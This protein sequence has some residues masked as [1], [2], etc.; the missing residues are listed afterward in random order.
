MDEPTNPYN[1][2]PIEE[3]IVQNDLSRQHDG[4]LGLFTPGEFLHFDLSVPHLH[5]SKSYSLE[6]SKDRFALSTVPQSALEP[7]GARM[8]PPPLPYLTSRS[9]SNSYPAEWVNS[10]SF[11]G[12]QAPI[13]DALPPPPWGPSLSQWR[14]PLRCPDCLI[15]LRED[16]EL[17]HHW[18][19]V[20]APT[21]R[22]WI[23]VQPENPPFQPKK[24]LDVCKM[25][26]Q[27]KQYNV[28]Y[29][30]AAH[31]RRAHFAPS[32]RG[33]RP[34]GEVETSA[35]TLST[36]RS[37][38]PNVG[39]LKA[40]GWLK[41]ITVP[42]ER[43]S[44]VAG[45]QDDGVN[46]Y[47]ADNVTVSGVDQMGVDVTL[48]HDRPNQTTQHVTAPTWMEYTME[49]VVLPPGA[50]TDSDGDIDSDD[51][52]RDRTASLGQDNF[53]PYIP[54]P[55][56]HTKLK[57]RVSELRNVN[58]ETPGPGTPEPCNMNDILQLTSATDSG[59]GTGQSGSKMDG[60]SVA[61]D[62]T[63]S[64][65]TDGSQAPIQ[66][67]DKYLLEAVFAREMSDRFNTLMQESFASRS[68]MA[69][70]LLYA[71][72]VMIGKRASSLPQRGAASFVRRGRK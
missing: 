28:D 43:S 19:N 11:P 69:T 14:P 53:P 5:N 3:E 23:C 32:K 50:H 4:D 7:A 6:D 10:T 45:N 49:N 42:N 12:H 46:G 31:L 41:E 54:K 48:S 52:T 24:S 16:H 35:T 56:E 72:S 58:V 2:P 1:D 67:E 62:D 61:E 57:P 17:Q 70:D 30:A 25:C 9:D 34:R 55:T 63:E 37:R 20:H 29:N 15:T 44:P 47:D 26:K 33:R 22:V 64:I 65:V 38:G 66:G 51:S 59:Y 21:K 36:K 13:H 71:F 40:H 27:G 39:A 60:R 68:D 8:P 18:E